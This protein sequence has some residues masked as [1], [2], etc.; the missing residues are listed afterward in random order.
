[1]S[2]VIIPQ[3]ETERTTPQVITSIPAAA[4]NDLCPYCDEPITPNDISL[5]IN[6]SAVFVHRECLI[7]QVG[8]SV[9]HQEKRCSCYVEGAGDG[10]EGLSKRESAR[11]ATDLYEQRTAEKQSRRRA[12][13]VG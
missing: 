5:P 11:K 9:N 2:D 3:F 4:V 6:N 10:E 12:N 7:R 13:V 1:M 8:G